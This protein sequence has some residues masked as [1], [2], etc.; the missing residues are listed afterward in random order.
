M[1]RSGL[2]FK[3][4]IPPSGNNLFENVKRTKKAFLRAANGIRA[5]RKFMAMGS[6]R[7]TDEY[8]AWREEQGWE[9]M[10]QIAEIRRRGT[11]T[12]AE[13]V[14]EVPVVVQATVPYDENRDLDNYWKAT[15]DLLRHVHVIPDDNMKWVQG[16]NIIPGP[17]DQDGCLIHIEP[18]AA[19]Y[20]PE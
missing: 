2:D 5:D 12:G 7:M 16:L 20:G 18:V 3:I 6:R 10:T 15:L 13:T 9:M 19:T 4:A 8:K 11:K 17:A 14:F 1:S